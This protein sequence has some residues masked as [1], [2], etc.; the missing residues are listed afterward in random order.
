[1]TD[2]PKK[3]T[4]KSGFKFGDPDEYKKMTPEE[5]KEETE[6]MMKMHKQWAKHP[7]K[8]PKSKLRMA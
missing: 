2:V 6:R 3:K 7:L 5:R 8:S 1:M 4:K